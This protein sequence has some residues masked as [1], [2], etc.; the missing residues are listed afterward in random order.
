M[1]ANKNLLNKKII[2]L[3]LASVMMLSGCTSKPQESIES[4][5]AKITHKIGINQLAEHPALDQVREGFIEELEESNLNFEINYQNAQGDTITANSISNKFV[6][7]K[8]DLILGIAT[9]SAQASKQATSEIP[10]LFSA[11]TDPVSAGLVDSIDSPGA[12]VT[13]TTDKTP[14]KEQLSLLKQIDPTI[15]KVGIIFNTSE[16]N[17]TAQ[18]E[19]ATILANELGLEI[20]SVGIN[21]VNDVPQA[22]DSILSKVDAL[23][24]ITDNTVAQ[25]LGTVAAKA[26]EQKKIVIGAEE[27]HVQ[28][29]ALMTDGL[30]YKELGK[31]T[32]QM[33]IKI[34]DGNALPKDLKVENLTNTTKVVNK[35]TIEALGLDS[36]LEIFKNVTI[37]E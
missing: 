9:I 10:I 26:I 18:V 23:Y 33:A 16:A 5:E 8:S 7:D 21:N 25:A 22:T 13:G 37:I 36:N 17:S 30:S 11:V 20:I 3:A 34:L 4:T 6:A 27:A 2:G 12:N 19:E 31:Q 28:N 35:K 24:T 15:K 32:A 29:G 14:M 1:K